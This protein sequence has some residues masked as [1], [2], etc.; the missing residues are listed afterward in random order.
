MLPARGSF[1]ALRMIY[2]ATEITTPDFSLLAMNAMR[3]PLHPNLLSFHHA[4]MSFDSEF[5]TK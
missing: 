1:A 3:N 2:C 4:K 5:D